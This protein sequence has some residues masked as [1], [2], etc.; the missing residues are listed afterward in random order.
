VIAKILARIPEWAERR[1]IDSRDDRPVVAAARIERYLRSGRQPWSPGYAE[2]KKRMLGEV[3]HDPATLA[4]FAQNESLPSGYGLR[5][6]ERVVEYP[7]V[8]A[9]LESGER[10]LLDAGSTLNHRFLLD[11]PVLRTRQIVIYNLAPESVVSRSNVSYL[12]GD[13][14][15]TIL[16]NESFDEIVCIS[17]LEHVGM[18]NGRLY[19]TDPRFSE[20]KTDDWEMVVREFA[21]L[22]RPGG[23][24][25]L[26]VPYGRY[27]NLGWLQQFDRSRI[28]RL[29]DTLHGFG[30]A[31]AC[32]YRYAPTG[33]QV[34]DADT[35]ADCEYYDVHRGRSPDPDGAAAARAVACVE[36]T[37][38]G[39]A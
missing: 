20:D 26:T 17:T 5:L 18:D 7:W 35:C 33:W 6:D 16:G 13:L 21:R 8:L 10:Q 9:R 2:Y 19:S 34:A 23:R 38:R 28:G 3:V 12:Y 32:Y 30:V 15:R 22:L 4:R 24:L 37:R 31:D 1:L 27:Q 25:F 39:R 36:V 11:L 14:R 29:L